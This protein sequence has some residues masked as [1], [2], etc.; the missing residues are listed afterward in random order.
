[1]DVQGHGHHPQRVKDRVL[2]LLLL[3]LWVLHPPRQQND[4]DDEGFKDGD[5]GECYGEGNDGLDNDD[6]KDTV[7]E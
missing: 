6:G 7:D 3:L 1:M 4:D 2:L 5:Y